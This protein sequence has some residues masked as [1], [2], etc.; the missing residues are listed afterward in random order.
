MGRDGRLSGP[1]LVA[2]LVEGLRRAGCD[3]IDIGMAPTPVVYFAAYHLRAGS[4]VVVT[5][6]HNPPDYNGFKIV[7]GGETLSGEAI[8]DLYRRI[9]DGRLQRADAPGGL[10]QREVIADYVQRIADDVQLDRPL[11]VVAD[12]GNGIAGAVAPQLLEAIGAGTSSVRAVHC[13]GLAGPAPAGRF[14]KPERGLDLP[15]TL[16]R[17]G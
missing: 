10:Q 12:A 16:K 17:S 6:S 7:I 13:T 4:C 15:E 1:E 9:A 5:G 8:T 3:V 2:G 14:A 11:K